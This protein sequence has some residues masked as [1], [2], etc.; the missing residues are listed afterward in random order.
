MRPCAGRGRG[1]ELCPQVPAGLPVVAR[2]G[3]GAILPC[4]S[5]LPHEGWWLVPLWW[6][7]PFTCWACQYP[8]LETQSLSPKNGTFPLRF[9]GRVGGAQGVQGWLPG[10]GSQGPQWQVVKC[11]PQGL[12]DL[13]SFCHL[14]LFVLTGCI[15]DSFP[16]CLWVTQ[17]SKSLWCDGKSQHGKPGHFCEGTLGCPFPILGLKLL[18]APAGHSLEPLWPLR[19]RCPGHPRAAR[20]SEGNA[21]L[22][23]PHREHLRSGSWL[24]VGRDL[25]RKINKV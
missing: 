9:L 4:L 7:G 1:K 14:F 19:P 25:K 20:S 6:G 5:T 18:D 17:R 3:P 24:S 12:R 16:L 2:P 13:V 22:F 21:C 10:L 11:E 15:I 8:A 23:S